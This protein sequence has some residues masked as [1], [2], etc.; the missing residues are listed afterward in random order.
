MEV[1]MNRQPTEQ[2][3]ALIRALAPTVLADRL[4]RAMEVGT[5]KKGRVICE[6]VGEP[7]EAEKRWVRITAEWNGEQS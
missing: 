4:K 6:F 3:R 5:T 2:E 7:S 1:L